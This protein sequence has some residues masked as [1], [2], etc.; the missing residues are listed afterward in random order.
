LPIL[1]RENLING[2]RH[3]KGKAPRSI[4]LDWALA[5]IR[6]PS[7]ATTISLGQLPAVDTKIV[8]N[9]FV[10]SALL[11]AIRYPINYLNDPEHRFR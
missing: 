5:P 11:P 1:S 7:Y 2:K 8:Q 3:K 10:R 4:P 9:K 6:N